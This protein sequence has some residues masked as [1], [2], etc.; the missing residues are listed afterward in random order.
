MKAGKPGKTLRSVV[1]RIRSFLI[2]RQGTSPE[3][4]NRLAALFTPYL[5]SVLIPSL[6]EKPSLRNGRELET[7]AATL[8]ALVEGDL[9]QVGD[10]LASRFKAVEAATQEGNW[11]VA[12]H[13]ELLGDT[14]VSTA[15]Q[16]EREAALRDQAAELRLRALERG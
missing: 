1:A 14:R 13:F 3:E 7:L 10:L 16:Q 11:N 5:R 8:D 4:K 15:T 6:S 12:R 9:D 2:G